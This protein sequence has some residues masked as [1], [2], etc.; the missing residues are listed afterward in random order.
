MT[1]QHD[2]QKG[3]EANKMENPIKKAMREIEYYNVESCLRKLMDLY[4]MLPVVRKTVSDEDFRR[5]VDE[6]SRNCLEAERHCIKF[7]NE[8][9]RS[10]QEERLRLIAQKRGPTEYAMIWKKGGKK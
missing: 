5:V 6:M 1:L 9:L 10:R 4:A 7:L 8:C 3:T 2:T